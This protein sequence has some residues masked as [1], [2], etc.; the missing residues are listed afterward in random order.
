MP[1]GD[2]WLLTPNI[3]FQVGDDYLLYILPRPQASH[4]GTQFHTYVIQ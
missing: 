2:P 3:I 4:S 1:S